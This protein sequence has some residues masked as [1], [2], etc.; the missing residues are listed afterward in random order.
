MEKIIINING[1][2]GNIFFIISRATNCLKSYGKDKEALEMQ[3]KV[4]KAKSYEKAL[5]IIK[6][7]VPNF[8]FVK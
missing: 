4:F 7:Y 3:N 6:E 8:E 2:E 1:T 5:S